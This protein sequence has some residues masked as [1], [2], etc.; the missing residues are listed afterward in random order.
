MT[1]GERKTAEMFRA[2]AD[3]RLPD[4][5]ADRLVRRL[6]EKDMAKAA[7]ATKK[8][9]ARIALIAATLT[10][11]LGFVPIAFDGASEHTV[12]AVR[13]DQIRPAN[14]SLPQESQLDGLAILGFCRELIRRRAKPL[15]ERLRKREDED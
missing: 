3:V 8:T 12:A 1:E 4:D 5:F 13:C 9:F 14:P 7:K 6:G 11:L 2:C 15:V 10:L